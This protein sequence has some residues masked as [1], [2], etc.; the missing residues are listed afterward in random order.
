MSHIG[1]QWREHTHQVQTVHNNLKIINIQ[2]EKKRYNEE[3]ILHLSDVISVISS[4]AE[5]VFNSN[6]SDTFPVSTLAFSIENGDFLTRQT[7]E[8]TFAETENTSHVV[9]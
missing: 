7:A 4:L 1:A 3:S 6:F 8:Q 9:F 2:K 5:F